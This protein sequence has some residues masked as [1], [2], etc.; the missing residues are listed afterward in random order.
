ML[1]DEER[2]EFAKRVVQ[3]RA[4][5]MPIASLQEAKEYLV[6]NNYVAYQVKLV[7]ATLVLIK[8]VEM[9]TD[10]MDVDSNPIAQPEDKGF[11]SGEQAVEYA[12]GLAAGIWKGIFGE[13]P[14]ETR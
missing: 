10:I 4:L 14:R 3:A 13:D 12:K 11:E 1:S 2:A 9:T 8:L 7:E 5:D 6:V